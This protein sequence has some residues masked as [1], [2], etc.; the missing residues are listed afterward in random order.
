M[1]S[2]KVLMINNT[3]YL[4]AQSDIRSDPNILKSME[5]CIY[6]LPFEVLNIYNLS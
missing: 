4:I 1:H 2:S 6:E 5:I 3:I